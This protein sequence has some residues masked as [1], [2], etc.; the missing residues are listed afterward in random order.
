MAAFYRYGN[1]GFDVGSSSIVFLSFCSDTISLVGSSIISSSMNSSVFPLQFLA[2]QY[3][4]QVFQLVQLKVEK[5]LVANIF[6][7][8]L[9][10]QMIVISSPFENTIFLLMSNT[11][12]ILSAQA[13]LFSS[14]E[15]S[16]L[17]HWK[18]I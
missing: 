5:P 1:F 3:L 11:S 12:R 9:N 16:N 7:F 15:F 4:I 13:L 18:F 2:P 17:S 6:S 14:S 10:S 8:S